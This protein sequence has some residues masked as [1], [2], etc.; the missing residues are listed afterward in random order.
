M[1]RFSE[2]D[3]VQLFRE[4]D[5]ETLRVA[6]LT[7]GAICIAVAIFALLLNNMDHLAMLRGNR[8]ACSRT[9]N[10][11]LLGIIALLFVFFLSLVFAIGYCVQYANWQ[12]FAKKKFSAARHM[13]SNAKPM[14]ISC[15]TSALCGAS[16]AV[17]IVRC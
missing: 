8:V 11:F 7:I 4:G 12:R 13:I 15:G 10:V 16:L 17:V 5:R 3:I 14:I 9:D 2:L 1:K 6:A